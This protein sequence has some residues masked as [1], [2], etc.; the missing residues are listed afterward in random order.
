MSIPTPIRVA[1]AQ[2]ALNQYLDD[3]GITNPLDR[4]TALQR[5]IAMTWLQQLQRAGLATDLDVFD[6]IAG[7]GEL[8]AQL[9][10][11]LPQN[12]GQGEYRP[13]EIATGEVQ[14]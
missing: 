9:I 10:W 12:V 7:K 4:Y 14:P 2:A 8:S 13:S 1:A 11:Q 6:I 3:A 5:Q